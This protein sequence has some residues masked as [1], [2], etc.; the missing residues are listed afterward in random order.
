M[1]AFARPLEDV[2]RERLG[3]G[4]KE[5]G[6]RERIRDTSTLVARSAG[7]CGRECGYGEWGAGA[8]SRGGGGR[9]HT[10]VWTLTLGS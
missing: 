4:A 2:A 1:A 3:E 9:G 6:E 7:L 8:C 5:R 10:R